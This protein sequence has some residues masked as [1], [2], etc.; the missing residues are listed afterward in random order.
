MK[1]FLGL[2]LILLCLTPAALAEVDGGFEYWVRED[3]VTVEV[4]GFAP[5]HETREL[6]IPD[7][8]GGYPVAAVAE[9]AFADTGVTSLHLPAGLTRL[10][11]DAFSMCEKLKTITVAEDHPVFEVRDGVLF[12]K[13]TDT[14]V[15][16]PQGLKGKSYAVPKG[17]RAIGPRAF[18]GCRSL[19]KITLPEGLEVIGDGAFFNGAFDKIT[20][21][22]SL[23]E[24]GVGAFAICDKLKSLKLPAA[25][26]LI[27]GN[28][29]TNT[30]TKLTVDKKNPV[31]KMTDGMLIDTQRQWLIMASHRA[32]ACAVPEG[33]THIAPQACAMIWADSVTLPESLVAIG[34]EAF[35][36]ASALTAIT[37][38]GTVTEIGRDAF[39]GTA[40]T[41][42]NIPL[43]MAEIPFGTFSNCLSLK[44]VTLPEGL[45]EIGSYAFMG[46]EN[47][48]EITLPESLRY[49][50]SGA[51]MDC[52]ALKRVILPDG[53][54]RISGSAFDNCPAQLIANPGTEGA[55]FAAK[56]Q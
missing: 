22:E 11:P 7:Q 32:D 29:L 55:E 21:P 15:F 20:L 16:Y 12:D 54:T 48:A 41:E 24:I 23:K 14:L 4:A 26:S 51:F 39:G 25:V 46:C 34:E 35:H 27:H 13:T 49:I 31:F 44:R 9:N 36:N 10:D 28:P 8:L 47:L 52:Y 30:I 40:I 1:K 45:I 37:L 53:L 6:I 56:R 33:I 17:T 43:G 18:S 3:E 50:R 42:M 5:D 2:L 19:T 38:P